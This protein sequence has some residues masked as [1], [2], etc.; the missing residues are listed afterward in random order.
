MQT[1]SDTWKLAIDPKNIGRTERWFEKISPVAKDTPVPGIIQQVFPDYCGVVWYWTTFQPFKT[2][3]PDQRYLIR[4]G[5]V[6]YMAE[7]WVNGQSVGGHEGG[8]TP[9]TLDVTAVIRPDRE[10]FLAV[11]VLNPTDNPIEEIRL[12]DTPHRNKAAGD[13]FPGKGLN[14]GG[15]IGSVELLVVPAVRVTDIF[16]RPEMKTGN[17]RLAV[18]IQNDTGQSANGTLTASTGPAPGGEILASS[19]L[20]TEFPAGTCTR[21]MVVTIAQVHPW[22]LDDPYLY[23]VEVKLQAQGKYDHTQMVRCGFRELRVEKGYFRLNGKRIFLRSTH[24]GNHFPIGQAVPMDPDLMRRDFLMAKVAG[25]NTVRFIAGMSL[26]EQMDFC[27]EIGLMVYEESMAGWCLEDSPEMARRFDLSIRE[28]VLRDRNHPCVTIWGLLNETADGAVFRQAVKSLSLIRSLDDTRLVLL[29]SGRWDARQEIGSLSNPDSREWEHQWGGET[30]NAEKVS[31]PIDP[32]HG[33]YYQQAG[34][35]HVYPPTPIRPITFEFFKKLGRDTKPVV[36]TECGIGSMLDVIR[37]SRWFEQLGARPDL[38]DFTLFRT[39][40]EKLET[41]WNRWGFQNVYPFIQ[42]LLR[43]SQRLHTRQRLLVFDLIRANPKICGYNLT[44]ILDHGITGEGVWTF[45][46]EWKPGTAEALFDGWAPLRWCLFTHPTHGYAG[47]KFKLE[48]TLANEDVL[49]PGEYP[50]RLCVAGPTGHIWEK[51]TTV[52]IPKPAPGQDGPLAVEVFSGEVKLTGPAGEYEFAAYMERGGAPFGG[53]VKFHLS[54]P[55][56]LPKVKSAVKLWGVDKTVEKWLAGQGVKCKHFDPS[57]VKGREVIVVGNSPEL[58]SDAAGWAGLTGRLKQGSTAIF[59]SPAVFRKKRYQPNQKKLKRIGTFMVSAREFE[60][61]NVP[62]EEWPVFT[63]EF[64][65]NLNYEIS[66]LSNA[67]YTVEFGMCEGFSPAAGARVFSVTINGQT[68]LKGID[69][70]KEA[71]GWHLAV[72]RQFKIKPQKGKISINFLPSA[73][74]PSLCRLRVYDPKGKLLVEDS[75]LDD[76][77]DEMDWLPLANKGK[78]TD[79]YDWL[80]HKECVAKAHPIFDGLQAKGIMDW[81]YYGP[82]ISKKFFENLDLPQEVIAAA[83]ATG[84]AHPTGYASG[85]ML[86][87]HTLGKGRFILNTFNILENIGNHP[88]ADRLLLNMINYAA[89]E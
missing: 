71:G 1:L 4:F 28:M 33:G 3:T 75:A 59:L 10:N 30:P 42:D 40:A 39:M 11:R 48:A 13:Y 64:W 2:A 14:Y 23:R 32:L 46:R 12:L 79:F 20:E 86:T 15:M 19:Q 74:S 54:D 55:A 34:D 80:Y 85:L 8:E 84:Y 53:R 16:A 29:A 6:D 68:V 56:A 65:G 36:V 67:E 83:F 58:N 7:V 66:G 9:F 72:I 21:E 18:T 62:K 41:D 70:V 27:D 60:I 5:A 82:V 37:G 43:E 77:R 88:A 76:S 44:G 52:K 61:P 35:A 22:N 38:A 78:C 87:M 49:G 57:T 50:V 81:D 24:T 26:I 47:R 63:K 73:G 25:Y 89:K 31:R 51:K 45:F 17:I 69:F